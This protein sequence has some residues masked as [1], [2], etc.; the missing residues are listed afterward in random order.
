MTYEE[1][2]IPTS[3][4]IPDNSTLAREFQRNHPHLSKWVM[5]QGQSETYRRLQRINIK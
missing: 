3:I 5:N 4:N 2:R 1:V